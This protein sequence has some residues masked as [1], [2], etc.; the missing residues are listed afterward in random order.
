MFSYIYSYMMKEV[1]PIAEHVL[2]KYL[3]E[4]REGNPGLFNR[5]NLGKDGTLNEDSLSRN[6]QLLREKNRLDVLV[7]GLNEFLYSGQLAVKRTLGADHE[8]VVIRRLKEIRK[9]PASLG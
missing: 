1:G 7:R 9:I 2:D 6:I 8:A 4:V 3:R 5:I